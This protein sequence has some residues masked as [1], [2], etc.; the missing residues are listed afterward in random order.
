MDAAAYQ[1][2]RDALRTLADRNGG[3]DV[4]PP[5]G[6]RNDPPPSYRCRLLALG[7]DK[8]LV[9]ERPTAGGASQHVEPGATLWVLAIN[10][11]HR[12]EG[13][14]RVLETE[15]FA[16]NKDTSVRALRLSDAEDI[17]SGQR[18][19]FF[20]VNTG[21]SDLQLALIYTHLAPVGARKGADEP[22]LDV[23]AINISGG[24]LG[25]RLALN[26]RVKVTEWVR[27]GRVYTCM[28]QLPGMTPIEVAARLVHIEP[29]HNDA[30]YLGMEFV[31]ENDH[32]G[33]HVQ[34]NIA[35]YAAELQRR[36]LRRQRGA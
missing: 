2:W 35:K 22:R 18:R 8:T 13:R 28:L 21:D 23:R 31:F 9:I 14:C 36:Q 17:R 1:V 25:L 4:C 5:A 7:D 32:F 12:W 26:P 6:R 10:G 27:L 24:G 3:V 15:T 20:R 29:M 19:Q 30:L 34:D 16:L 11:P 33:R